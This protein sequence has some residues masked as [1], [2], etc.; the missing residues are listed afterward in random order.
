[1]RGSFLINT[2]RGRVL[3]AAVILVAEFAVLEAGLRMTNSES[4]PAFQSLFMQD[5][6]VGYRLR[7]SARATYTTMEY[8]TD[9][10]INAQGVRDDEDIGPKAPDERRI[11]VLGDSLVMSIQVDFTDTYCHLLEQKLNTVDKAHRWRVINA[12]VQGYGPV[13]QW[14]FYR[15]VVEPL[16][17]DLVIIVAF[18]GNAAAAVE[19]E[20]L[21]APGARPAEALGESAILRFRRIARRSMVWQFARMR[22]DQLRARFVSA[23]REPALSTYLS[24][25]PPTVARGLDVTRRAIGLIASR[26][27]ERGARTAVV[28]MPARFQVDDGDFERLAAAIHEA[29]ATL[30]RNAATER[31]RTAL[32][33]LGLPTFDMLPVLLAQPDRGGLFFQRNVHLTERGHRVA[34][35]ALY[36]F[37]E[38]GG[39]VV[40]TDRPR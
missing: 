26:A 4:A 40:S 18:V 2:R 14:L 15:H 17:P 9:L 25:P 19:K 38:T 31:Y 5:A 34:A 24:E 3:L 12:G 21:L 1:M 13:D 37:L 33:P 30:V 36:R 7:P 22:W 16:D 23:A 35:D 6:Q 39:L 11:V 28:L 10:R 29:G 27:A 8:S 32:E 20:A